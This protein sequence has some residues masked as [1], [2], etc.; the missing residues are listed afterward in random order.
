MMMGSAEPVGSVEAPA[1]APKFVEDLPE[2]E[3]ATL[4]TRAYG[5]GLKN[6]G[7]TCYMNSTLQCLYSVTALR[8]AVLGF[9]PAAAAGGAPSAAA[10]SSLAAAAAGGDSGRKLVAA[11][12]ELFRDLQRGGEPFPP[13]KFLLM[14]RQRYPQ[15]A[16]QTG[17]GFYMQQD[18]EECWSQVMYTLKEQLK[19]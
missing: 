11:T 4:E 8:D 3:Q 6:L 2:E 5:S 18:A 17:E 7:N 9:D 10:S 12:Q 13:F 1:N 14:L 19:V 15:F 16:Q